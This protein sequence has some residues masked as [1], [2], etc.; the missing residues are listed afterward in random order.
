MTSVRAAARRVLASRPAVRAVR[1]AAAAPGLPAGVRL[2]LAARVAA[3]ELADGRVP[4]RLSEV[5]SGLLDTADTRHAAG[6][7]AGAA[8]ALARAL[9][10]AFHRVLHFDRLTSPL[11]ADPAGYLAPLR[12]STA[13]RALGGRGRATPAAAAPADRPLRLLIATRANANFLAAIRERYAAH[14]RVELRFLDL[15]A[16][17]VRAPLAGRTD[18]MIEELLAGGTAYGAAVEEWL[19]PHLDWA[20]TVFVDWCVAT[21]VLFTMVDPG[22]TRVVV[23]AHSFELFTFWPHLVNAGRLDDLVVVSPPMRELAEAVLPAGP[24][25]WVI[26]NAVDLGALHRPKPADA[27]FTLGLVGLSS[28]AKDPRWAVEVVRRLRATDD[29]YRL[30]LFGAPPD[31]ATNPAVRDQVELLERDLAELAPTG[32]VRRMG[33]VA[34]LPAA[35]EGVGVVLSS[36][37]RESFHVGLVEGAASGALPVVRDWPFFAGQAAG[38]RS[39]FPAEWVVGT[40]EEAARRILALTADEQRW[41]AEGDKAAA[42]ALATWDWSVTSESFDRLLL[43]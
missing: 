1:A 23:R 33:H 37:V 6:D 18:A 43:P 22:T 29:R 4:P 14:P 24:R 38:A 8:R 25:Q 10:L 36:S 35:L 34:D 30:L 2:D 5:V 26:P 40:P 32:A 9:R 21:A 13:A 15:A 7:H 11:A 16:D 17:P 12:A 42:H 19:R 27:R 39:L 28:V 20:D 31:P 3:A 41:R